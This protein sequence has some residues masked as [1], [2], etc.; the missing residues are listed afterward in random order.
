MQ[1]NIVLSSKARAINT[2]RSVFRERRSD[3]AVGREHHQHYKR[4]TFIHDFFFSFPKHSELL[5]IRIPPLSSPTVYH[6]TSV[7]VIIRL[8]CITLHFYTVHRIQ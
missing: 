2:K 5:D 4:R 1:N 6:I 7:V 3:A 8:L